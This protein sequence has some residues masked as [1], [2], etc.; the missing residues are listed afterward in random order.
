VPEPRNRDAFNTGLRFYGGRRKPSWHAYRM[1]LVAERLSSGAV[2]LW[3]QVRP[4]RG[5]TTAVIRAGGR[6]GG[7]MRVARVRTNRW[8]F[9]VTRVR[10]PGAARLR[11]RSLWRSPSGVLMKSRVAGAGRFI[12]YLG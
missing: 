9:F 8:G 3:G 5:R 6:S 11:Y 10:R 2:E 7:R 12:R 4:A 1:P